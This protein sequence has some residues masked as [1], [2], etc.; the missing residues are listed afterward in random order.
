MVK[1]SILILIYGTVFVM[2]QHQIAQCVTGMLQ[3]NLLQDEYN[4][5]VLI[6]RIQ[7]Q[8][9]MAFIN[10][11]LKNMHQQE[12]WSLL[13]ATPKL[14]VSMGIPPFIHHCYIMFLWTENQ[15]FEEENDGNKNEDSDSEDDDDDDDDDDEEDY[16][17]DDDYDIISNLES[18]LE[19][20]QSYNY[21]WNPR[22]KFIIILEN[23]NIQNE[24]MPK[25]VIKT[26]WETNNI[27]NSIIVSYSDL[28]ENPNDENFTINLYNWYPYESNQCTQVRDITLVDLWQN[29]SFLYNVPLF[30][31]K[32]PDNMLGCPLRVA[33]SEFYPNVIITANHTHED[34][35]VT[36]SYD[37]IDIDYLVLVADASN[38]TIQ[39]LPPPQT[40]DFIDAAI[41]RWLKVQSGLADITVGTLWWH[42]GLFYLGDPTTS[43][44]EFNIKWYVP[45]AIPVPRMQKVLEVFTPSLWIL[46]FTVFILT[47]LIFCFLA[48]SISSELN[49]YKTIS[50]CMCH[51]WAIFL[52]VSVPAH[53]RTD[54]LRL[55][56]VLYVCYSL[57][58]VNVY[59]AFFT[60]FL[61][62]PG[63]GKQI[64]NVE[65]L[66]A[67]GV[68]FCKYNYYEDL[69]LTYSFTEPEVLE[70]IRNDMFRCYSW[71]IQ[72]NNVST[73]ALDYFIQYIAAT[74]GKTKQTDN[75]LCSMEDK[76]TVS[77]CLYL[78]KGSPLLNRF[79][80]IIRRALEA[81]LG[82]KTWSSIMWQTNLKYLKYI[83]YDNEMYFVFTL[84]HFQLFFYMFILGNLV[85]VIMFIVE[86]VV[87]HIKKSANI[88]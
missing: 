65:D 73:V 72:H 4:I 51:V 42:Q 78:S 2:P 75:I 70:Y 38:L 47:A 46:I 44:F 3:Q 13:T 30:P 34:G 71:A 20:L 24:T 61:V 8:T 16:D 41:K 43:Y 63:L 74:L 77:F 56:F 45:C 15:D 19:L 68:K 27:V 59:Q 37:G 80:K 28:Q 82:Q 60:T 10:S 11:L 29:Y 25:N 17:D 55:V 35:S 36:Y 58:M 54:Q 67:T 18:Q 88:P 33:T 76:I 52:G 66:L 81:G 22:A 49:I 64:E 40:S 23:T 21:R 14:Q 87:Y 9:R 83:S 85:S 50:N 31:P 6:P 57:A 79:N 69:A 1:E 5:H 39:Y 62:E 26:L 12:S 48:I 53:P 7:N 84:S 86:L 32:I